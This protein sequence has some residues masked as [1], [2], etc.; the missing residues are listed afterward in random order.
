MRQERL[1]GGLLTLLND[2]IGWT[3]YNL[4]D[5]WN[6]ELLWNRGEVMCLAHPGCDALQSKALLA[7]EDVAFSGMFDGLEALHVHIG[8]RSI[9]KVLNGRRIRHSLVALA[10]LVHIGGLVSSDEARTDLLGITMLET[11]STAETEL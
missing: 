11:H 5:L 3:Y 8:A 9:H 4:L 6:A 1:E 2:A 7:Q 10:S